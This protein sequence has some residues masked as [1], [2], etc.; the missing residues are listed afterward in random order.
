MNLARMQEVAYDLRPKRA[1]R[2]RSFALDEGL[3]LAAELAP[4]E[5]R[6]WKPRLLR[7]HEYGELTNTPGQYYQDARQPWLI[8]DTAT[9]TLTTA[10]QVLWSVAD[11]TP[12]YAYDWWQ[13]KQLL[14]R[15]IG[16]ITTPA[17]AGAVTA[18]FGYGT[19]SGTTGALA[20]SAALAVTASQTNITWRFE[21][22]VRCRAVGPG[23]SAGILLGTGILEGSV[24]T[25]TADKTLPATAPAQVGSLNLATTSGIH[26]QMT[27]ATTTGGT[28]VVHDLE[29]VNNN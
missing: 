9:V 5:Q 13:G 18:Q 12:T 27:E 25:S 17:T 24:F 1:A 22:R 2:S 11:L 14:L 8:A 28:V 10:Q 3:R 23:A 4:I 29:F 19:A 20:T 16:R 7:L 6:H 26:L 21:G 15:C